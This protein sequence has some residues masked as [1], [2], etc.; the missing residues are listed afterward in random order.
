[1]WNDRTPAAWQQLGEWKSQQYRRT[2]WAD[3]FARPWV[4]A[5]FEELTELRT[6]SFAG[7]VSVLSVAGRPAA[8]QQSLRANGV[9]ACWFPAY[10]VTLAPYSPGLACMFEIVRA[11]AAHGLAEIDLAK[12]D[13]DYKRML[14]DGDRTVSLGWAERPSPV[15]LVRRAQQGPQR[16]LTEFVLARP[17]LRRAA[18]RT[19][20]TLG[21]LRQGP[22]T[23]ASGVG[24]RP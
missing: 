20:R 17:R 4:R 2:G 18:R 16:R 21:R 19:L 12:G 3:V 1:V 9:L 11:A 24:N 6:A 10:D 7:T 14:K 22:P 23:A 13:A 8:I 15:A 5:V